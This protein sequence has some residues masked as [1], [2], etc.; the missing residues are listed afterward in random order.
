MLRSR[1]STNDRFAL[2]SDRPARPLPGGQGRAAFVGQVVSPSSKIGVGKFLMVVPVTVFGTDQEGAPGVITIDS[3]EP[4]PVYLVGPDLAQTGDLLICRRVD[5]RWVAERDATQPFGFTLP[6]C[7]CTNLP[8]TL[9]LHVGNPS[10]VAPEIFTVPAT[11]VY[12]PKPAALAVYNSDP[13]GYY[14]T[15][16]FWTADQDFHWMYWFGCQNGVYFL[17]LLMLPIASGFAGS[18]PGTQLIMSWLVGLAGNTCN[19]LSLT[20]GSTNSVFFQEAELS[21]SGQSPAS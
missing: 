9:Y 5:H 7:P 12:G 1:F 19:P 10:V 18:Y 11:F 14:S 8:G 17:Q 13:I 3:S 21:I 4:I 16:D 20:N 2:F 6:G 15:E